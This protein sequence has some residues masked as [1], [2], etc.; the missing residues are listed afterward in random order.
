METWGIWYIDVGFLIW[1]I[2]SR[3]QSHESVYWAHTT[4]FV[5]SVHLITWCLFH[6]QVCMLMTWF[7]MY[8]FD[9][10]L[11]IHV[12]LSL[13][14]TWH[15]LHH[16]LES[17]W[18]PWILMSRSRRLELVD[19][20]SCWSEVHNY[21]VDHWQAVWDPVLPGPLLSSRVFPLWLMSAFCI[22]HDCKSLCILAFSSIDDVIF[23]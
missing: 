22:V 8:A 21:S 2:P 19:S 10:D 16:S 4:G 13:H 15:S 9:S 11:S 3:Y 1:I 5:T 17:F 12:C 7:S 20:P 6:V 18:L 23:S 14:A